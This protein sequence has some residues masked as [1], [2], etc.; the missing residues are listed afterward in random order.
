LSELEGYNLN[1][2]ETVWNWTAAFFCAMDT[3]ESHE[4][5]ESASPL[6]SILGTDRL[7]QVIHALNTADEHGLAP[8]PVQL[9][10][11]YCQQQFGYHIEGYETCVGTFL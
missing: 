6:C 4:A 9:L 7:V 11:S 5:M 8:D 10:S 3:P 1:R 2:G